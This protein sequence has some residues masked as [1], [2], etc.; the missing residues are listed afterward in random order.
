MGASSSVYRVGNVLDSNKD[1]DPDDG[2][3]VSA[4]T[5]TTPFWSGGVTTY[6]GTTDVA[7]AAFDRV[8]DYMGPNWW[9]RDV[10]PDTPDER[11]IA[12]ARN[13]TGKIVAW[14]DDPW[15]ASDGAEWQAL[16]STPQ[17]SRAGDWD[18]E[19][20]VGY[21]I[22]DG[23]PTYWELEHNLN[24]SARDDTGDFDGDGYTNL[25]EYLNDIAAW[26]APNSITFNNAHDD[27]RYAHI[28]NWDANPDAA[29]VHP[30]QPSRYDRA[31]IDNG[32]VAVD[33]VGQH[34]GN[35]LLGTH[36]G[37][38]ATLNISNGWLKIEDAPQGPSDG[39][40]S[41]GQHAGAT[42]SL[43]LSGGKLVAEALLKGP[44]GTFNFTGGVLSA[45]TVNF[46]LVNNGGTIAPGNSP[47]QT[48]INGDFTTNSGALE[49]ELAAAA[50]YDG[51]GVNG[52][53]VL[54]GDLIVKLLGGFVPTAEDSFTIIQGPFVS[55]MTGT[56]ANLDNGRV[57]IDGA[58]G[59]F[60]VIIGTNHVTL[61]NFSLAPPVLAGDY[62][63]D[64]LVDAA[65]YIV[66]R[67]L[68]GTSATL[69]NETASPGEVD[70]EDY[71]AWSQNFGS[72]NTSGN[73]SDA[74][75]PE[76]TSWL[77][78]LAGCALGVGA[79]NKRRRRYTP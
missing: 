70:E 51:I 12:E 27:G 46:P 33:A 23:M 14:A 35:L 40:I 74:A 1:A 36:A 22:G 20:S 66:W 58:E 77:L 32:T 39:S 78:L 3:A 47:G 69:P 19:A 4:G 18:T 21:G 52:N 60:L 11:I 41:I 8:L 61:S 53:T 28:L 44:G 67:K 9:T 73:G 15:N 64:G 57:S 62:N 16:R 37:D 26:P 59:S 68:E 49:I 24:P 79:I 55:T 72:S 17:V 43:N 65:D 25:E 34:A 56:F 42:A 30:W 76:P 31:V 10:V 50:S 7:R 2:T 13:G 54:G 48:Y 71:N 45:E 29:L 63:D 75:A 6:K 5:I 38:N